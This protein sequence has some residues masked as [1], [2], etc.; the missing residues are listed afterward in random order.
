MAPIPKKLSAEQQA[1]KQ[2]RRREQNRIAQLRL[3]MR[4]RGLNPDVTPL[5]DVAALVDAA[6]IPD[7]DSLSTSVETKP[8]EPGAIH[9]VNPTAGLRGS[10]TSE[11][12]LAE[13]TAMPPSTALTTAATTVATTAAPLAT[14][15]P[16][17]LPSSL[18][19]DSSLDPL[20]L[21]V[22]DLDSES[23]ILPAVAPAI[24]VTAPRA[25]EPTNSSAN[26]NTNL[27]PDLDLD[28]S[29]F[30]TTSGVL[31]DVGSTGL[32]LPSSLG[33]QMRPSLSTSMATSMEVSGSRGSSPAVN[34]APWDPTL[35]PESYLSSLSVGPHHPTDSNETRQEQESYYINEMGILTRIPSDRPKPLPSHLK[36][37][38]PASHAFSQ[39]PA[40]QSPTETMGPWDISHLLWGNTWGDRILLP[41]FDINFVYNSFGQ[42]LGLSQELLDDDFALSF[43]A[44][45][46]KRYRQRRQ[47]LAQS[48]GR[49]GRCNHASLGLPP[50][51]SWLNPAVTGQESAQLQNASVGQEAE[52]RNGEIQAPE[53]LCWDEIPEEYHPPPS[54]SVVPHH[55]FI[56]ACF[57]WPIV[58]E[59]IFRGI[60]AGFFSEL[61]LC[62]ELWEQEG[63]NPWD[64]AYVVHGDDPFDPEAY[65]LSA[66]F[67]MRWGFLFT[68]RS[69]T[70]STCLILARPQQFSVG[71]LGRK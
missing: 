3:R 40:S 58:R 61:D 31:S 62:V 36:S 9:H 38:S 14:E 5:S 18:L 57:P 48:G 11:A 32:P 49:G 10:L 67:V 26:S 42:R 60:L 37:K 71:R 39:R 44:K 7:A 35:T 54:A 4:R 30:T 55:L 45:D 46:Y 24:A 6:V 65:E 23:N 68:R 59:R 2:R 41:S 16:S 13:A 19:L 27:P 25:V 20:K 21:S 12:M 34:T 17:A 22:S 64:T 50:A 53:S 69:S 47:C 63:T 56:D 52:A 66:T 29:N 33:R 15:S 28:L 8:S 70:S 43:L 51:E 1:E